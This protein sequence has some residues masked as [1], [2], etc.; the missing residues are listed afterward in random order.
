MQITESHIFEND[1]QRLQKASSKK[2]SVRTL[3]FTKAA[4]VNAENR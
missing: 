4:T 2:N 3:V 1:R